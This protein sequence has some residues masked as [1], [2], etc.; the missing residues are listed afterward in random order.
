MRKTL[1]LA[2]TIALMASMLLALVPTAAIASGTEPLSF[3]IRNWVTADVTNSIVRKAWLNAMEAYMGRP[4]D[5]QWKSIDYA[6]RTETDKLYLAA[7]QFENVFIAQP[8]DQAV[9]D[10]LGE[11][12]LLVNIA[13]YA[14]ELV[15]YKAWLDD[16]NNRARVQTADGKMYGFALGEYGTH[17][18]NQQ[19]FAYREDVFTKNSINIPVTQED[20]YL[21][22]KQLKELY[23]NSYPVG[24]GRFLG[25]KYNGYLVWLL[26]NHTWNSIYYNGEKYVYGPA[27][28]TEAWKATITFLN[29]MYSEGL[30]D[31]EMITQTNDQGLERMLNGY[32]FMVPSYW[33][34]ELSAL[35]HAESYPDVQWA[36]AARP[37]S[38]DG[39]VGWKPGSLRPTYKLTP[40]DMMV[41]SAKAKDIKDI[42]KFIDY[43]YSPEIMDI[44]NWGV[45]GVTYTV[46]ENGRKVFIDEIRNASAPRKAAE[47]YGLLVSAT[48]FPGIRDTKERDAWSGV[49]PSIRVFADGEF[50]DYNDMWRFSYDYEHQEE[51]VFP[52]EIAPPIIY[53]EDERNL[54]VET[55]TTLETY[56]NESFLQFITGVKPIDEFESWQK[57][58]SSFGD[59][60]TLLDIMNSKLEAFQ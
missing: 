53:T 48:C 37:L 14:D 6:S 40:G 44:V 5:I 31:P 33:A 4:L 29:R 56:V 24:G 55:I 27:N 46:D 49:F 32:H 8:G 58:L 38:Y 3:S 30:I 21:A 12:G 22:A 59:Y 57:T 17:T 47:A 50:K 2:F 15:Y 42:V 16:N 60:E 23:P 20:F 41:I 28:D 43:Q 1:R 7:G 36:F 54:R 52:D 18:G 39:K 13:E 19:L 25:A 35:N 26:I 45:E 9:I 10:Q 34:G 11:A 51:S